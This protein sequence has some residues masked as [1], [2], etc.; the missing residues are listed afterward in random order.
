MQKQ[1]AVMET[2][3]WVLGH[4]VDVLSYLFRLFT[5]FVP[6][7]VRVEVLAADPR[8]PQRVYGYQEMFRRL[9][10]Q[11][12]LAS[13][14]PTQALPQFHAGEAAALALAHEEAWWLLINEQRALTFARQRGLK[15]VTVPEF[16]VYLYQ[17]R[18]LSYRSA[19]IKLDEIAPNTGRQ[20]MQAARHTLLALAQRRGER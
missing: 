16:I 10:A 2:S 6:E 20:V 4:R 5:V 15:A 8:Y 1:C 12:A 3:F 18:L 7:A 19:L 9:E 13:R 17:A 11:G 14:N